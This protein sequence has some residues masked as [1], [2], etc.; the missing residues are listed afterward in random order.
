MNWFIRWLKT[1]WS[2]RADPEIVGAP[3]TQDVR[4][5]IAQIEA[6]EQQIDAEPNFTKKSAKE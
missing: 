6:T 5:G 1:V 3:D 4:E 2:Y